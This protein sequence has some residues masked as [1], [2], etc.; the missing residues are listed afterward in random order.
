MYAHTDNH[1][2]TQPGQTIKL[3]MEEENQEEEEEEG[4]GGGLHKHADLY[5]QSLSTYFK[6]AMLNTVFMDR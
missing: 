5:Q 6:D 3:Q 4:G 1:M 2:D